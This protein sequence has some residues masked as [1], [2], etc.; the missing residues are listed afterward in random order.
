MGWLILGRR[1]LLLC[2]GAL[3]TLSTHII[4]FAVCFNIAMYIFLTVVCFYLARPPE[5]L[6]SGRFG[7]RFGFRRIPAEETIAVCFCG[8]SKST[9]LGVSLLYAM[10]TPVDLYIKAKTSVPVL[11]YTTEQ[12]RIAHFFVHLFRKWSARVNEKGDVECGSEGNEMVGGSYDGEESK[13]VNTWY[14]YTFV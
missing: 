14:L 10:W 9:A 6:C 12:I 2:N 4:V 7:G 3:Q 1:L 13:D 8:P 5:F 11:L